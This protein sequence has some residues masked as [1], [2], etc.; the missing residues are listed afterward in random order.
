MGSLWG[1]WG[2]SW[3][4]RRCMTVPTQRQ[5]RLKTAS[6]RLLDCPRSS[7]EAPRPRHDG[8][9]PLQEG[10]ISAYLEVRCSF[11]QISW[12]VLKVFIFQYFWASPSPLWASWWHLHASW[13]LPAPTWRLLGASWCRRGASCGRFERQ[14]GLRALQDRLKITPRLVL[15]G[16]KISQDRHNMPKIVPRA[17]H[18]GLSVLS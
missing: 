3:D 6:C 17:R 9:K 10:D 4:P 13:A 1:V 16:P 5:D 8:S 15:D 2:V 14:D 7:Q 11:H 18:A 12:N